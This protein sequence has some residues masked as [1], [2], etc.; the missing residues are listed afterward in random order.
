MKIGR[1]LAIAAVLIVTAF[2]ALQ[3]LFTGFDRVMEFYAQQQTV[4]R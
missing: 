2:L 3:L 4:R 1:E